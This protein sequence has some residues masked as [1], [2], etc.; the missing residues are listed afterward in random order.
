MLSDY[1]KQ[2]GHLPPTYFPPTQFC[3]ISLFLKII[4]AFHIFFHIWFFC[5]NGILFN[6]PFK[7][8]KSFFSKKNFFS[9]FD[10]LRENFTIKTEKTFLRIIRYAFYSK[11]A[12]FTNLKKHLLFVC[13]KNFVC[14]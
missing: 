6:M 10:F 3:S 7:R 4:A 2:E 11:S 13:K 8:M 12:T 1:Q 14:I 9:N 5:W